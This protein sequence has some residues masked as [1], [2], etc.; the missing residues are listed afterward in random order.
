[1]TDWADYDSVH[2]RFGPGGMC[3]RLHCLSGVAAVAEVVGKPFTVHWELRPACPI[4][5]DNLFVGTWQSAEESSPDGFCAHKH[6]P[7][8]AEGRKYHKLVRDLVP[9]ETFISKMLT[10]RR[11]WHPVPGIQARIEELEDLYGPTSE[12]LGL[13]IRRTDMVPFMKRDRYHVPDWA[14]AHLASTRLK[15]HGLK[16]VYVATCCGKT[17]ASMRHRLGDVFVSNEAKFD[18]SVRGPNRQTSVAAAVVDMY[19]L[20][21]CSRV[22]ATPR[23]SLSRYVSSL[24]DR[25]VQTFSFV[26]STTGKEPK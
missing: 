24:M 23:S 14:W 26:K 15:K 21:K 16:K 6:I 13:H 2:V 1:M 7:Q 12:M 17:H 19:M 22:Y 25:S 20:A 5:I 9:R 10:I 11:S 18:Q 8:H 3:A 4:P